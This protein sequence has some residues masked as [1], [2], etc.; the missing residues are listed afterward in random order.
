MNL[1]WGKVQLV[2]GLNKDE[3]IAGKE[4]FWEKLNETIEE[5]K[6][7]LII[8]IGK[9]NRRVG[10]QNEQSSNVIKTHREDEKTNDKNTLIDYCILNDPIVIS[11]FI[12]IKICKKK[13]LF[14]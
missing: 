5:A 8:I 7:R 14:F 6:N 2:N 3:K 1:F 13:K 12:N 9:I 10:K 11:T 4:E